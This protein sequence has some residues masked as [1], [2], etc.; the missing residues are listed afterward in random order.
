MNYTSMIFSPTGGTEKVAAALTATWGIASLVVDLTNAKTDFSNIVFQPEDVTVIAVPS[1]G[2][3]VPK[4]AAERIQKVHG[5][6]S[7]AVLVC[8]YGNREYEDTLAELEDLAKEAGFQV[9]AAVAGIAEHSI[10]RRFAAGRPDA[11]DQRILAGFGQTIQERL[12]RGEK[13]GIIPGSRPYKQTGSGMIPQTGTACVQC[14]LCAAQCPAGAIDS[15]DAGKINAEKCIS[16]MRC[17][18]ICPQQ[19]KA[20]DPAGLTKVAAML[21]KVC[22]DRKTCELY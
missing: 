11:E 16:C 1:Y 17:V 21:E 8:V 18:K 6:G 12:K 9:T 19:A 5:N 7:K 10:V 2:G 15:T 4:L 20:L 3:R 13:S 14:G 22:S